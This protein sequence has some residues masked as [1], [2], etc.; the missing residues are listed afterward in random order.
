[1]DGEKECFKCEQV[2]P[3]GEFYK[4]PRMADGHLGKCMEC[5]RADIRENRQKKLGQIR[6]YDRKRAVS[7]KG[8]QRRLNFQK[9]N[10]KEHPIRWRARGQAER[11]LKAGQITKRPCHFCGSEENLEMHHP[12]YSKPL[13]VYWLCLTCHRRLDAMLKL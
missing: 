6:A 13:R 9:R 12:N 11:A 7:P 8:I 4:H 10:R 1:M 3:L 5:A 2:L